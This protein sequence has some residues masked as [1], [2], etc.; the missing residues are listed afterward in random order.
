[1]FDI[2]VVAINRFQ[3]LNIISVTF[4]LGHLVSRSTLKSA[5]LYY[6]ANIF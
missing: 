3:N 4:V 6:I 2:K 5:Q 1:M